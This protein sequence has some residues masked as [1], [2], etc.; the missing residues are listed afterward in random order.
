MTVG[1]LVD[2]GQILMSDGYR[3][4]RSELATS[5]Y[6]ILRVADIGHGE[7]RLDGP[8]FVAE[9]FRA[10]I[11]V[12]LG[13]A[14]D[15]L[16]TTKGTVG[17]VALMPETSELV[18][19]SPQLCFFRVLEG[20]VLAAA[21][22]RYWLL[23][24]EF[25]RQ[26]AD[27]KDNTDMAAYINLRD[28]RSLRIA[29]PRPSTQHAIAELLG[30]LDDKIAANT[31]LADIADGLIGLM[32]RVAIQH[33]AA[34]ARPL[35]DFF[36]VDF[37][38]AFKGTHFSEPGTGRALIRIRDL[39]TYRSQVWTT[40]TRSREILVQ[41]GDVIVGMDAEFR[42]TTW[43]GTPGLLNQRVCRVHS[44]RAPAAFVRESLKAPLAAIE[45][46]KSGTTV[47]HL[48]KSDL[49]RTVVRIPPSD[50]VQG[51]AREAEGLYETGVALAFENSA[52]AALRDALLPHLMSGR[53]RVRDA[54]KI[55]G[56]R[57]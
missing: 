25:K 8:E 13:T 54:E 42:P 24:P 2:R 47:I 32:H 28:V 37:G 17:R 34:V 38:E 36:E 21:F 53:L 20:S 33:P 29:L 12:K 6:R 44:K 39:R 1:E 49:E 55:V 27:R 57:V 4:K 5:G 50:V 30:A 56:E 26:A 41:P 18:V 46:G 31:K 16:L 51:F 23:S 22:L 3:T 10:G 15:V 45:G 40:E 52:L 35:F 19:Y 48:N 7:V 11:G 14:G 9:S 43:L